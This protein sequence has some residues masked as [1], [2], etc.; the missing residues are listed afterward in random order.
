MTL[1]AKNVVIMSGL[2][3]NEFYLNVN[4]ALIP[5]GHK[6]SNYHTMLWVKDEK[7]HESTAQA[8]LIQ[9]IHLIK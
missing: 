5:T 1:N 6:V 3:E 9:Y 8:I 4:G 7:F 2:H